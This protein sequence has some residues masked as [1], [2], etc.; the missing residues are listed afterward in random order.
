VVELDRKV[1][2]ILSARLEQIARQFVAE[3]DGQSLG[4][5]QPTQFEQPLI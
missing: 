2:T 5:S 4:L 3:F 1:V